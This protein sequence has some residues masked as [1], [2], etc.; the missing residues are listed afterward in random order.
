MPSKTRL[1]PM[2][3]RTKGAATKLQCARHYVREMEKMIEHR[4]HHEVGYTDSE[5]AKKD[6]RWLQTLMERAKMT[7]KEQDKTLN[8]LKA[9]KRRA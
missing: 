6:Y 2:N 1:G 9:S 8:P 4:V 3:T 5:R 7:E